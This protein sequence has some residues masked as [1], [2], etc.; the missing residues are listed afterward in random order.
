MTRNKRFD[1]KKIM[2]F[3]VLVPLALSWDLVYTVIQ[4]IYDGA[5]WIDKKGEKFFDRH[6]DQL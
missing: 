1:W 5:T 3:A 2:K 6:I 4:W